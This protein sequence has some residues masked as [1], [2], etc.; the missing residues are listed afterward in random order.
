MGPGPDGDREYHHMEA[1]RKSTSA[2]GRNEPRK[3]KQQQ[4]QQQQQQHQQQQQYNWQAP[5]MM[6]PPSYYQQPFGPSATFYPHG[7]Y[8]PTTRVA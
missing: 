4:A 6:P 7:G 2:Q 1:F 3:P 8:H 5:F